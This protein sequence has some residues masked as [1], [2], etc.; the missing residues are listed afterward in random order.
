[1]SVLH[2]PQV[3]SDA[4]PTPLGSSAARANVPADQPAHRRRMK[5]YFGRK[6]AEA[7]FPRY[8]KA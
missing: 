5:D 3:A 4:D 6:I 1:M 2:R 8:W 7:G